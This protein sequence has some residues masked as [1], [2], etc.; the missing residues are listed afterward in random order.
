MAS[1]AFAVRTLNRYVL[2]VDRDRDVVLIH[3]LVA[4]PGRRRDADPLDLG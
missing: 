3:Q 1:L 2:D 4:R